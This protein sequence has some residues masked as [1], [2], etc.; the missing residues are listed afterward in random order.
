MLPQSGLTTISKPDAARPFESLVWVWID[1][2]GA[3]DKLI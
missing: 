2:Y 3:Y 1:L